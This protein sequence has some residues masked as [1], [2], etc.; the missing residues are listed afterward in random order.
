MSDEADSCVRLRDIDGFAYA[1]VC[2]GTLHD[3]GSSF[4]V[5]LFHHHFVHVLV[6]GINRAVHTDDFQRQIAAELH[7]VHDHNLRPRRFADRRRKQSDGTCAEDHAVVRS[8]HVSVAAV[9]AVICHGTGLHQRALHITHG[10]RHFIAE[11]F[12]ADQILSHSAGS[13]RHEPHFV[14]VGAVGIVDSFLTDGAAV[15]GV[16]AL[17][18]H[19]VS[20]FQRDHVGADGDDVAAPLMSRSV[21]TQIITAL[22]GMA[23]IALH[24]ASADSGRFHFYKNLCR[25]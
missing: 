19:T 6:K 24:I 11:L 22:F 16:R 9:N 25:F 8:R 1:E 7:R 17:A 5:R 10:I 3:K 2:S 15:A 12:L 23:Q 18:G 13:G 21:G 14:P 20:H 4:S